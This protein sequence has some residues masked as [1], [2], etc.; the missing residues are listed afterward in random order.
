[1]G[2]RMKGHSVSQSEAVIPAAGRLRS[3]KHTDCQLLPQ[4]LVVD[5][6][7]V[8]NATGPFTAC[9]AQG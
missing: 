5:G 6:F 3:Y 1:M 9:Q 8:A 7:G 4:I 2:Q